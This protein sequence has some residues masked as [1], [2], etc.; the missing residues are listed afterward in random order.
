MRKSFCVGSEKFLQR[1]AILFHIVIL[2]SGVSEHMRKSQKLGGSSSTGLMLRELAARISWDTI[3]RMRDSY[4][5]KNLSILSQICGLWIACLGSTEQVKKKTFR[6]RK[7]NTTKIMKIVFNMYR[8]W[9]FFEQT[10]NEIPTFEK[11]KNWDHSI[12]FTKCSSHILLVKLHY[13]P[14]PCHNLRIVFRILYQCRMHLFI[15]N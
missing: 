15:G 5:N 1:A 6:Y 14:I 13:F 10:E 9:S 2:G 7:T 12:I 4:G 3:K 11:Y 8:C